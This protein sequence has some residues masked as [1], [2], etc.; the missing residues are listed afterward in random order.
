M[1]GILSPKEN[2]N[3]IWLFNS[4]TCHLPFTCGLLTP[5]EYSDNRIIALLMPKYLAKICKGYQY[6]D[7][8]LLLGTAEFNVVTQGADGNFLVEQAK[9]KGIGRDPA[10]EKRFDQRNRGFGGW[11]YVQTN[12][13]VDTGAVTIYVTDEPPKS[14]KLS[15]KAVQ[16]LTFQKELTI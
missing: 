5:E 7:G 1:K 15:L 2:A 4:Y 9:H 16:K 6:K 8:K 3:L 13:F 12:N 10:T 14:R 11:I